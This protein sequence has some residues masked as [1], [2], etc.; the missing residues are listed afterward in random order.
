MSGSV[1]AFYAW[2]AGCWNYPNQ[3]LTGSEFTWGG[4]ADYGQP[5]PC[6]NGLGLSERN[7]SESAAW[8]RR[9][10]KARRDIDAHKVHIE[11]QEKVN[12]AHLD[13]SSDDVSELKTIIESVYK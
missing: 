2:D 7:L 4:I 8:R 9:V 3:Q 6:P 12:A 11:W 10:E 5:Y 1:A 13:W